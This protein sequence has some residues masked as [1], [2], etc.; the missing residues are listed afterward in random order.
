MAF[1]R[2]AIAAETCVGVPKKKKRKKRK[3]KRKNERKKKE[4]TKEKKKQEKKRKKKKEKK[5]R[6]VV[7]YGVFAQFV[8]WHHP[9]AC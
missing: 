5:T 1:A 6:R 3:E 4:K 7:P 9:S 2:M 8:R